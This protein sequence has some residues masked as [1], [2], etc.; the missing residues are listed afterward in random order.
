MAKEK[1]GP[2]LPTTL[3]LKLFNQAGDQIDYT[4][5]DR[6]KLNNA[7]G[8]IEREWFV[9]GLNETDPVSANRK[10]IADTNVRGGGR[11]PEGQ[12]AGIFAMK[13]VYESE[14]VKTEAQ[15]VLQRQWIHS[16]V[17]E[18]LIESKNQY[19]TWKLSELLGFVDDSQVTASATG[20]AFE[21][22]RGDYKG[23]KKFNLYIP[24]PRLTSY[25]VRLTQGI[26]PDASL[27][28][29]FIYCGLV[30]ILNRAG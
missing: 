14:S 20:Q 26:A 7:A 13:F 23:I 5:Y 8:A 10:T 16:C 18:F 22:S 25:S 6:L 21:A 15:R 9:T 4:F 1:A 12:A 27:D 30:G 24:L 29:D 19:G 3:N 17:V 11:I 28:G 2:V